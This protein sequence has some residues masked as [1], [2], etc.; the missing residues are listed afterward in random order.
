VKVLTCKQ[1]R[2]KKSVDLNIKQNK[3]DI[4]EGGGIFVRINEVEI[5]S[6]F[7]ERNRKEKVHRE[8]IM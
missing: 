7:S 4:M 3:T 1:K 5:D 6:R 2:N 8:Y